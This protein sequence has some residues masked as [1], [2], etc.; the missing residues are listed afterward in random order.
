MTSVDV[1]ITNEATGERWLLGNG[2]NG[3]ASQLAF[4][5]WDELMAGRAEGLGPVNV[6]QF[7]ARLPG[8]LLAD[9]VARTDLTG[10]AYRVSTDVDVIR[11]QIQPDAT[12]VVSYIES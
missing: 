7:S 11:A 8:Q 3:P 5:I 4:A 6:A 2:L 9:V 10:W 12:Y 1:R